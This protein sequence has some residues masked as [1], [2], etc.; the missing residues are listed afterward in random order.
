MSQEQVLILL[1]KDE[2][3]SVDIDDYAY[4]PGYKGGRGS[5]FKERGLNVWAE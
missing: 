2:V 4:L 1:G 3:G 5:F